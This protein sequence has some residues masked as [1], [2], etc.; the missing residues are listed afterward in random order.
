MVITSN[1]SNGSDSTQPEP[2]ESVEEP[3]IR[4]QSAVISEKLEGNS[5]GKGAKARQIPA[6]VPTAEICHNAHTFDAG[7]ITERL[8][9]VK[10]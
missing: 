10:E 9:V 1:P 5:E 7:F 2:S 4:R 3:P 6:D 8:G